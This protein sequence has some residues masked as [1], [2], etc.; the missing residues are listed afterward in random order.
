MTTQMFRIEVIVRSILVMM[1]VLFMRRI[2]GRRRLET[3]E[4]DQDDVCLMNGNNK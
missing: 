2:K 1:F 4:K 3:G